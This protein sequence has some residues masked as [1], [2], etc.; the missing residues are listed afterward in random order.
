MDDFKNIY[1]Q[2]LAIQIL[3]SAIYKEHI[4]PAYLFSGPRGVG[5]KKTA[6]VFIKSILGKNMEKEGTKR[7]IESN[8]HPD[9]LWIEPSYIVQGRSISQTQAKSESISIKSPAQIR[10]N[11]IQ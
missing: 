2:D 6:K 10:L 11:Q 8:N 3:R 4:S 1:G 7:K 5:R 9:L